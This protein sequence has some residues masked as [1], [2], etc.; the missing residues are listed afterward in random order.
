[1]RL[2]TPVLVE[3]LFDGRAGFARYESVAEFGQ[4][5][6]P[7]SPVRGGS[8]LGQPSEFGNRMSMAGDEYFFA[9]LGQADEPEQFG[10]SLFQCS[11]HANI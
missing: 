9:A 7:S 8:R 6:Q 5:C 3:N 11:R 2:F 1:M 10:L 4:F